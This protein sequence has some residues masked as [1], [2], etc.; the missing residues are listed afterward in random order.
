MNRVNT[1]LDIHLN[2]Y[3]KKLISISIL[4]VSSFLLIEHIWTYGRTDLLDL[5]GHEYSALIGILFVFVWNIEWSQW[6]ELKL[7][8]IRNWFR[9]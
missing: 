6:K 9:W 1:H 7:W 8:H 2:P 4:L 5:I 3:H